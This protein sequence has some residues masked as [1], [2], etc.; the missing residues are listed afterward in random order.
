MESGTEKRWLQPAIIFIGVL[1]LFFAVSRLNSPAK[2]EAEL[3]TGPDSRI[4]VTP[5]QLDSYSYG[6]AT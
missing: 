2:A 5:V 1:C 6:L 4:L 3:Q